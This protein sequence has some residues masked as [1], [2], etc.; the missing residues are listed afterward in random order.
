MLFGDALQVNEVPNKINVFKIFEP[1]DIDVLTTLR[2][3][4]QDLQ[5]F[6]TWETAESDYYDGCI[7]WV[8]PQPLKFS[9]PL[10]SAAAPAL[11]V[12]DQLREDGYLGVGRGG[13]HR[14][15]GG[16]LYDK[17]ALYLS[18]K[19]YLQCALA[20]KICSLRAT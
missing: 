4:I 8:N 10:L 18:N 6:R 12:L 7:A 17:R 1:M 5:G 13:V 11:A 15:R 9:G 14:P 3:P 2:D 16:L 20:P 19:F